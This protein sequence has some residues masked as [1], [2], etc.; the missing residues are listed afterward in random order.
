MQTEGMP[1]KGKAFTYADEF[2]NQELVLQVA[3]LSKEVY[4]IKGTTTPEEA[5]SDETCKVLLWLEASRGTEALVA[6][7]SSNSLA[8]IFR[9][10]EDIEDWLTNLNKTLDESKIVDGSP[11]PAVRLHR[12]FQNALF[13][14]D[15]A[16]TIE[17]TL[18]KALED[19][20]SLSKEIV[21]SGH[22]LGGALAQIM[23]TYL[24]VRHPDLK[25]RMITFGEPMVGNLAYKQWNESLSNISMWRFV[26]E[27]DSVARVTHSKKSD[28]V[29]AGHMVHMMGKETVVYYQH[30]GDG[31]KLLGAPEEWKDGNN[32]LD[33]LMPK[34]IEN[35]EKDIASNTSL[36][37]L[38][39]EDEEPNGSWLCCF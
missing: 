13:E 4:N 21:L 37:F 7:L 19:D 8:V 17:E 38:G 5:I 3:K 31:G 34:Y 2:S 30:Y 1:Q 10:S 32:V 39:S 18:M 23:T 24:S 26:N 16:N 15:A 35:I 27:D 11:D 6:K 14:N 33:H 12:G 28:Y 25:I 22:S 36:S 29:H 20:A 9:G